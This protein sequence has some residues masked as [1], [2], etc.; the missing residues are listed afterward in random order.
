MMTAKSNN[1][2][3]SET[4]CNENKA[5]RKSKYDISSIVFDQIKDL[6]E[7]LELVAKLQACIEKQKRK[8]VRLKKKLSLG[9]T[10]DKIKLKHMYTQTDCDE[11]TNKSIAEEITEAAQQALQKSGFVYEETSGMYYDYNSGYYYNAEYGLYYDGNS[12]TY[13]KYN[14]DTKTYDFHS[15]VVQNISI[16]R[17]PKILKSREKRKN[18]D[19]SHVIKNSTCNMECLT[20]SFTEMNLLAISQH[21]LDY[22]KQWPPC[23]RIIIEESN[24]ESLKQGSLHILTYEGGTLGREGDSHAILIPDINTSKHHLR[25][26]FD[27]ENNTYL[28]SDLGSRNGTYLNGKRISPS[29]MES[30]TLQ[31]PHGSRLQVGSVVMLCHVH[32]GNQTCGHCEPGLLQFKDY[33]QQDV[34]QINKID[35]HKQQLNKLRKK[36]GISQAEQ[37]KINPGSG[38]TDRAQV[39]RDTVGSQN[40]H[41]KT[42]VASLTES[43]DSENK[44]FKM[45]AKMGWKEGQSLGKDNKGRLEPVELISNPGTSGV[46]NKRI[47]VDIDKSKIETWTKVQERYNKIPE[48]SNNIFDI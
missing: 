35:L 34:V 6:P 1:M 15:Q 18:Q 26:S 41:E 25:F 36:F 22:A 46:G 2:R 8:L 44:G 3:I 10:K 24:V 7:V 27:R 5:T 48:A 43:I 9:K 31:V 23:M 33:T 20:Q 29:K 32:Q 11:A 38:Y 14:Q 30:D 17:D 19:I 12:G 16:E 21:V 13:L 39:R 40:P 45:L 37:G 4:S 42:K 47:T 28:I